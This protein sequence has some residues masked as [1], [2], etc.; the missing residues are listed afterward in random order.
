MRTTSWKIILIILLQFHPKLWAA[1]SN[2]N[3]ILMGDRAAG[4][5]GAFTALTNDPAAVLFYNPAAVA[6]MKG[7]SLSTSVSV[8]HKYD[9]K[10]GE[11]SSLDEATRR[12][13]QG[14]FKSIPSSSG[15]ILSYGHFAF[16]LSI[17]VPEY[18]FYSGQINNSNNNISTLRLTEQSLWVGAGLGK[19]IT[20]KDSLGITMYYTAL[21]S[22]HSIN[23]QTSANSGADTVL[24]T[25]ERS[26]LNNSLVYILGWH[27]EINDNW[28]MGISLR[29]PSLEISG[30]GTYFKT[31]VDTTG[32]S[33]GPSQEYRE[34]VKTAF[35]IPS[36]LSLGF[37]YEQK[38]KQSVSF[39]IVYHDSE[40]YKDFD[41]ASFAYTY[42]HKPI[43]NYS[44]GYEKY[45]KHSVRLRTGLFTNYSSSYDLTTANEW[46]PDKVDMWGFSAN[47]AI[48]STEQNS[49]TFG[50]Y[51]T[52]GKGESK[53]LVNGQYEIVD[54]TRQVFSMLISSAYYF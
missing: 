8:Y 14:S 37:A 50:G 18:N 27:H 13:N 21:D 4:M 28:K 7:H 20:K 29:P 53:Q 26:V 9:T 5:G 39:D 44:I 16:G 45:L 52:T 35:E 49:F 43:I 10:F 31:E 30:R 3:S 54:V 46:Q 34:D 40:T 32:P 41:D 42:R 2:Y 48:F 51:F 12:L 19:N 36:K 17:V 38:E 33:D 25:E 6:R 1:F 47:I 24:T 22:A 23:D 11:E 15:S